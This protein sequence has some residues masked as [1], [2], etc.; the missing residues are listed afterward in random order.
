MKTIELFRNFRLL[1]LLFAAIAI[2][3]CSDDDDAPEEENEVEVITDVVLVF[4][5]TGGGTA[6]RATANDPDALGAQPLAV[7]DDPIVLS[8]S[9]TYRLTFEIENGADPTDVEDIVEEIKGEDDEH[10]LFFSFTEGA[11][12][13]PAGNGNIDTASDPINYEDED[14]VAQDGSGN[15]VGLI[16]TWTTSDTALPSG[17]FRVTL[18]HQPDIKSSTTGANDG[19][20][21]FNLVFDLEIQ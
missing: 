4:T 6:I 3:S 18:K 14:S 9:T 21:D 13:D 17:S 15:P 1:A 19:D 11:F 5:P 20:T 7:Q 10:Q 8:A 2:V 12:S 16:T